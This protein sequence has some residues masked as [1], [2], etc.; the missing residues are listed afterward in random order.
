L[1]ES[2]WKRWDTPDTRPTVHDGT[3]GE[4]IA[5]PEDNFVARKPSGA[6][7][8]TAGAAPL[9]GITAIS[10][11]DAF[12]ISEGDTVL[13]LGANGGVPEDENYLRD[14]GVSEV[15]ERDADIAALVRE[16][17]PEGIAALLDLVSYTSDGFDAYASALKPC[18][19]GASPNSAAG[20]GPGRT[21][22]M[23]VPSPENLDRLGQLLE[24]STLRVHIQSTYSLARSGEALRAFRTAHTQGK[25]GIQVT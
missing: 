12:H 14:L 4:L 20:E 23:A 13:M 1:L 6:D 5:V 22:V 10:A 11:L 7:L 8:A 19:R 9:V 17:H 2:P 3:W 16:R 15:L 25:L 21:N 18:R 24:A